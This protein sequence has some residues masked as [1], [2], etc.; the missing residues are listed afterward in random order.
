MTTIE[1]APVGTRIWFVGE[2][3][4][5]RVR[6]RNARYLVCTKPANL[7]RT[8]YY[9]IVDLEEGIRGTENLIFGMGAESDQDC[10]EM[11]ERLSGH[12]DPTEISHRNRVPLNVYRIA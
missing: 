9:T 8:V 12:E 7:H 2:K 3:R 6:A 1:T 11:I 4:P 5:Y 10:E